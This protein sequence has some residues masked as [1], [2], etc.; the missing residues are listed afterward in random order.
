MGNCPPASKTSLFSDTNLRQCLVAKVLVGNA[1]LH[2]ISYYG[3][4]YGNFLTIPI[5][6]ILILCSHSRCRK[7]QSLQIVS[8]SKLLSFIINCLNFPIFVSI[9]V[10]GPNIPSRSIMVPR[11]NLM[12]Q[13]V[14]FWIFWPLNISSSKLFRFSTF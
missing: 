9:S 6:L 12:P 13:N 8:L 7:T 4:L 5:W 14:G 10:Y 11:A 2:P 3:F 1:L